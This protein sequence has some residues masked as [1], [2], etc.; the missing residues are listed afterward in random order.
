M[1]NYFKA[2]LAGLAAL[3]W[4][5]AAAAQKAP[6]FFDVPGTVLTRA[7]NTTTYTANTTV[8]QSA[9]ANCTPGTATIA[10]S[11]NGGGFLNHVTLFK[12][13]STTTNGTFIIWMF[14]QPPTLTTP[15][16][17]DN[18]AYVGPRTADAPN[19]IGNASCATATAT[20]DTGAG[21]WYDCTLSNPNTAGALVFQTS[22][23]PPSTIF[24]LI[25]VTA[26]YVP[27]NAETFTP[28]FS[29]FY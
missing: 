18:V 7:A 2:I 1:N 8:C 11:P 13:T 26:A 3:L 25:E 10:N 5:D 21:V 17:Q 19:Y 14:S 24:F 27:G 4:I 12:S 29:G 20:S 28:Y 9:S 6:Y 16:Q 22:G 15:A 23:A